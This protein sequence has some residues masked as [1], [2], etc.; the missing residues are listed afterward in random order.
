[1][2]RALLHSWAVVSVLC[3]TDGSDEP[4][5]TADPGRGSHACRN[6]SADGEA[7]VLHARS[8]QAAISAAFGCGEQSCAGVWA[9]LSRT[10][11]AGGNLSTGIR[12]FAVGQWRQQLGVADSGD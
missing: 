7:V 1:M 4:C 12:Q 9:D 5:F 2:P 3:G 10:Y 6:L 8:A 11:G